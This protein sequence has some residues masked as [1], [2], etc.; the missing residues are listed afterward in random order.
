MNRIH[1]IDN[2]I[3]DEDAD[4][5]VKEIKTPSEVND[6][7]DY[8]LD[9]FGGTAFPYN[10]TVL[11]IQKKY[12]YKA[13]EIH[14]EL[15]GFKSPIYIYK[16]FA[17]QS[18][19]GWSGGPHTDSNDPETWIEWSTVVYLND[20]YEGGNIY[21]PN[22]DFVY[23]PKKGSAVFFPSAGTEYIHGVTEVLSGTRYGMVMCHTSL[24]SYV[25]PDFHE[26]G[27]GWAAMDWYN[28]EMYNKG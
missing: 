16:I 4:A 19:A 25:D 23:K 3:S 7:P 17:N 18:P 15:N 27:E 8:Y 5:L 13:N 28:K 11:N 20:E 9:R 10:D 24:P 6:H 22:Q 26:Q 1:I 21:F 14:Q 12:A 2:F